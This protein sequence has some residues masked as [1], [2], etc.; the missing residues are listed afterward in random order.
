M[1]AAAL[2]LP[3]LEMATNLFTENSNPRAYAE[4]LEEAL[5]Q[6]KAAAERDNRHEA[7]LD[8]AQPAQ[9]HPGIDPN[10]PPKDYVPIAATPFN[11]SSVVSLKRKLMTALVGAVMSWIMV[12][13]AFAANTDA[14]ETLIDALGACFFLFMFGYSLYS[15]YKDIR[16]KLCTKGAGAQEVTNVKTVRNSN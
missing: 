13:R 11:P 9:E 5:V 1:K 6:A 4:K 8:Y 16:K 12:P 3:G 2:H 10:A 14:M 7:P 15:A